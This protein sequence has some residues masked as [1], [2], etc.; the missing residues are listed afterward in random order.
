M[1]FRS[2][3]NPSA[4]MPF[5]DHLEELRWRILWSLIALVVCALLAFGIVLK[6]D[7][8]GL[9]KHPIEPYLTENN[10]K[11]IILGVTDG[12]FISFKIAIALGVVVAS[13]IIFYQVWA[14]L[15]PA[16]KPRER[17][18]IVPALYAGLLLFAAGAAL[19][20]YA[21]LPFTLR[22]MLN[23]QSESLEPQITA[24]LYFSFVVK[25]MLGFGVIFE[26]PV[27]ITLLTAIGVTNSR[28]LTSKRRYAIGANAILA[29]MITPGDA[30]TATIILMGPLMLLYELSILGAKLVERARHRSQAAEAAAEALIESSG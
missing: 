17:R 29:A 1:K 24:P 5:L 20:Y 16:L 19:A 6:F 22:F 23:F 11:L 9:L 30:I 14:F 4:E 8:I 27:V 18:A 25:L 3:A 26:M 7:V 21:A 10:G 13:P 15:S 28:F 2:F 12:F